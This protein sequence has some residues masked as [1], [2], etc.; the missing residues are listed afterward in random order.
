MS[1]PSGG[2]NEPGEPETDAQ[3]AA[4]QAEAEAGQA[5]ANP[6]ADLEQLLDSLRTVEIQLFSIEVVQQVQQLTDPEKQAFVAARLHLSSVINQLNTA[7]LSQIADKLEQHAA[8]LRQG[9]Q[10]L[11]RSLNGLTGAAGWASAVNGV[12]GIIGQIIPLL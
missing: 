1:D 9:I 6:Q 3:A 4:D 8:E 5:L 7:Q 2:P 11:D 12:V 10:D